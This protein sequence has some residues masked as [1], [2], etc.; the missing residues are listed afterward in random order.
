MA[1][2][3]MFAST[4]GSRQS[5]GVLGELLGEQC[6]SGSADGVGVVQGVLVAQDEL[7]LL[8]KRVSG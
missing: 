4:L 8:L 3:V 2:M 6:V 7:S 1:S 5:V